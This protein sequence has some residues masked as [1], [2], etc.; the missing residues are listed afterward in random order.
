MRVWESGSLGV[1]ESGHLEVW[2]P[3]VWESGSLVRA[4]PWTQRI[5][6]QHR[7]CLTL[8]HALHLEG[9]LPLLSR[10][11]VVHSAAADQMLTLVLES[12][13]A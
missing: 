2:E 3:G 9:K 12:A 1:R 11:H 13:G 4:V 5:M 6:R 10:L 7:V 8:W